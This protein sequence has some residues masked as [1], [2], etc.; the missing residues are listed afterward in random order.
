M[1]ATEFEIIA[2]Y[3]NR[4][5]APGRGVVLG[6]GDDAAIP[7]VANVDAAVHQ[8]G[9]DGH[10]SHGPRRPTVTTCRTLPRAQPS[11]IRPRATRGK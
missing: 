4:P 9:A 6:T 3:F 10:F 11:A 5:V 7:V 8:D 1:P 2:R